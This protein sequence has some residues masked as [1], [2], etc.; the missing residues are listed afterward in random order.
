MKNAVL[1][2][3]KYF[4]EYVSDQEIQIYPVKL[5]QITVFHYCC[6]EIAF[7]VQ[8][9]ITSKVKIWGGITSIESKYCN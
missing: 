2:R 8:I 4:L 7:Y 9:L 3:F 1:F 5:F 6:L